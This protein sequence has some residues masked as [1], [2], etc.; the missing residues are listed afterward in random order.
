MPITKMPSYDGLSIRGVRISNV[1][2]TEEEGRGDDDF[3]TLRRV[4]RDYLHGTRRGNG[5]SPSTI[6]SSS[7]A[8]GMSILRLIMDTISHHRETAATSMT[9]EVSRSA[10]AHLRRYYSTAMLWILVLEDVWGHD[11]NKEIITPSGS[12]GS[13]VEQDMERERKEQAPEA[14]HI[15]RTSAGSDLDA[16]NDDAFATEALQ[17]AKMPAITPAQ[18]WGCA[19]LA[20]LRAR[21]LNENDGLGWTSDELHALDSRLEEIE[22]GLS[23]EE[24][25]E[26]LPPMSVL[27]TSMREYKCIATDDGL[28]GWGPGDS[29]IGDA[30]WVIPGTQAPILVRPNGNVGEFNHIGPCLM[31]GIMHGEVAE[32]LK[33]ERGELDIAEL[34]T[35]TLV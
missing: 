3:E 29:Q 17:E 12:T 34:E 16:T 1:T 11:N 35:I 2:A 20:D 8:R 18:K 25:E 10:T 5:S 21:F 6:E 15:T 33:R 30:V 23:G 7:T 32:K 28:L 27:I 22:V 26:F 9:T 31:P 24:Y 14:V 4:F 19:C 13:N